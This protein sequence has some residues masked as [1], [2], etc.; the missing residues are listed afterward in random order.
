[1]LVESLEYSQALQALAK[2]P[3]QFIDGSDISF[4]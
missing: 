4:H 1:L 3:L 2:L